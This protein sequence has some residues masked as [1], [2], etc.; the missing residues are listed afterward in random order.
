MEE[1]DKDA[2]VKL[3]VPRALC[4]FS[5]MNYFDAGITLMYAESEYCHVFGERV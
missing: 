2:Y 1:I 4:S 5:T 3:L